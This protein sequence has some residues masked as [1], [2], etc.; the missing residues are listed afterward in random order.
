[1]S[2]E[3]EAFTQPY[4]DSYLRLRHMFEKGLLSMVLIDN[5]SLF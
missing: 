3:Q 4:L 2:L 1:M 5:T